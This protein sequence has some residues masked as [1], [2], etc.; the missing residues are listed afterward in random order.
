MRRTLQELMTTGSEPEMI[1]TEIYKNVL[2]DVKD[3]LVLGPKVALTM[4]AADI[5]GS[6]INWVQ[7]TKDAMA[8]HL[9]AE[10]API[11]ID[12]DKYV[13][14]S[15]T[16]KKYGVR[17]WI[18]KEMIEDNKWNIVDMNIKT[19]TY[20]MAKQVDVLLEAQLS[21]AA[22][23]S[24]N[25]DSTGSAQS[26][27][28][29]TNVMQLV[30]ENGYKP[31]TM[32]IESNSLKD[33]RNL[34]TFVEVNKAGTSEM[35]RNGLVGRIFGMD[36]LLSEIVTD[37]YAY[38]FDSRYALAEAYKRAPTLVRVKDDIRELEGATLTMRYDATYM[39]SES[40]GMS[41]Y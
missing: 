6:S 3:N 37:N 23:A 41:Y 12:T 38:I 7:Q 21:A 20:Q 33:L 28:K 14:K 30:E 31:D 11:P 10:G 34:D 8:V 25:T 9:V 4:T 16:P 13:E 24:S 18:T 27:A 22:T 1:E 5:P 32:V 2:M 39:R 26:I 15:L 17:P 40:V 19:S 36:V 35:L 29:I